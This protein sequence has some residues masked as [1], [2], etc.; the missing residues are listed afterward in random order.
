MSRDERHE[1][2][3]WTAGGG[4]QFQT[5][6][7]LCNVKQYESEHNCKMRGNGKRSS[8]WIWM[9]TVWCRLAAVW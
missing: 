1:K 3:Q 7:Q 5:C 8:V 6:I 9:L 2:I 4:S